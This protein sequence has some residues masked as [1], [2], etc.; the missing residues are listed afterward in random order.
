[1]SKKSFTLLVI[2]IL[3]L[4]ALLGWYLYTHLGTTNGNNTENTSNPDLFPFG[5][6]GGNNGGTTNTSNNTGEVV[7]LG[8]T[9]TKRLPRLRHISLVPTAG[10][11]ASSTASST[12]IRY[13]ERATG[14][15]Y[16][17]DS[18]KPEVTKISAITIPKVYE[19]LFSND[20][21]KLLIRYIKDNT[22]IIRTFSAK[23]ATTTKPEEGISGLFLPDGIK[24]ITVYGNKMFYFDWTGTSAQGI[25]ANMDGSNKVAIFN[26]TFAEWNALWSAKNTISLFPK[27]SSS[28]ESTAYNLNVTT[29]EYVKTIGSTSGLA[30]LANTD[31]TLVLFS[32]TNNQG[33]GMSVVSSKTGDVN[34]LSLASLVEKCVWS[35]KEKNIVYCAIPQDPPNSNY[36]DNW[37][38]GKVTFNDALW[39]IDAVSGETEEV[40][41]PEFIVGSS[42]DMIKLSLDQEEKVILFTDKKDMTVWRYNL[43]E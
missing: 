5:P 13:I 35:V 31:G 39:K 25:V 12:M 42:M 9:E 43:V 20:S 23:I 38:K 21:S 6:G 15:I 40:F 29:G 7:D 24:D 1:M 11:I 37:Y 8:G 22:D 18:E 19:A 2:I 27:P 33:F 41:A 10:A 32:G 30:T 3:A 14:H 16:E 36:P 26:S 34:K 28:L 4:C 17:T